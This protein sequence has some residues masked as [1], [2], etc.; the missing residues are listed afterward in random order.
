VINIVKLECN[1]DGTYSVSFTVT[2]RTSDVVQHIYLHPP[3]GASI[4]PGY[5]PVNL[6]PGATSAPLTVTIA[7]AKPGRFCFGIS[8]HT[9]GMKTCCTFDYCIELPECEGSETSCANGICCSRA[10]RY[11]GTELVGQKVAAVT[12]DN[13]LVSKQS[14]NFVLTVFDMSGANGW[15]INGATPPAGNRPPAYTGPAGNEW[16]ADHLGT[17]FGVAIDHRGNIYVTASAAYGSDIAGPA[18]PGGVYKIETGT[19]AIKKFAVL[20]NTADSSG[21]Y[22]M[23]GNIAFDC[24]RKQL[25]V[26]NM[27]D[28][29][30]YRLDMNGNV[31]STFDHATQIVAAGNVP[32]PNDPPGVVR[33]GELLWGIE[34]HNNRVYYSVNSEDCG[35]KS[36]N[37]AIKNEIWSVGLKING[38]FDAND[39]RLEVKMPDLPGAD[40]SNLISDI[41][42]SRDGRMAVAER[43]MNSYTDPSAHSS[44]ALEFECTREGWV[45]APPFTA[46]PYKYNVGAALDGCAGTSTKPSN[47]AGGIDYDFDPNARYGFWAT[48]DALQFSSLVIYGFMGFPLSGGTSATG[49]ELALY[50]SGTQYKTQIGD[51]E[52][53]CPPDENPY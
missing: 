12:G 11:D 14:Q 15:G 1:R 22:P 26:T 43:S 41:S 10:P 13:Q 28:G 5:F 46:A 53:S 39:R 16:N 25:F 45:L 4:T 31:Q 19:G 38:D 9:E 35:H 17:V 7:G 37:P 36:S 3:A 18:G 44:R 34:V 32:E 50:T 33:M 42:F 6:A 40:F 21:R 30:I 47:A 20:P 51:I 52:I 23:L 49:P 2:N 24:A 8:L 29:R 27:D 48:G